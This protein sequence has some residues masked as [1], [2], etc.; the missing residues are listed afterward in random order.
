MALQMAKVGERHGGRDQ[1]GDPGGAEARVDAT[2]HLRQRAAAGQGF[3]CAAA[4]E[5]V[6]VAEQAD[7][8]GAHR[9]RVALK[10]EPRGFG[11]DLGKFVGRSAREV[12]GVTEVP[13]GAGGA[14]RSAARY[15]TT[16]ALPGPNADES[17]AMKRSPLVDGSVGSRVPRT[18]SPSAVRVTVAT[19][20]SSMSPRA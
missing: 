8:Q 11:T 1:D 6:A 16:G 20:T 7:E 10:E 12:F 17:S 9:R 18:S 5:R 2:E 3:A 15:S 14:E 19:S 13:T 4:D